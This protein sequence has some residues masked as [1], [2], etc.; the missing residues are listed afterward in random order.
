[1]MIEHSVL[2]LGQGG[3]QVGDSAYLWSHGLSGA[4]TGVVGHEIIIK[5]KPVRPEIPSAF[6]Q[7]FAE[8][9]VM[10]SHK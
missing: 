5:S 4:P 8:P 3:C 2:A 9:V 1:M 7:A 10:A 6:L